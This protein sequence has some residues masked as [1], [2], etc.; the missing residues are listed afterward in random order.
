[1]VALWRALKKAQN[2]DRNQKKVL[3]PHRVPHGEPLEAWPLGSFSSPKKVNL[4][5]SLTT[6]QLISSWQER[7]C[8]LPLPAASTNQWLLSGWHSEWHWKS[9]GSLS[10]VIIFVTVE[11]LGI[12][13]HLW[14]GDGSCVYIQSSFK[15]Q[16]SNSN[17]NKQNKTKQFNSS[18]RG[19]TDFN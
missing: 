9:L 7:M 16:K 6:L 1:M 10:A 18:F 5:K 2:F 13:L 11:I 17:L 8:S 3:F 15:K 14:K 19:G 4:G 12:P